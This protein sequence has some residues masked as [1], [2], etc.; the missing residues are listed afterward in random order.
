MRMAG[1]V[2]MGLFMFVLAVVIGVTSTGAGCGGGAGTINV[3]AIPAD[4]SSG[5]YDAEQ[6]ENAGHIRNTAA[7]MG[8]PVRAQQIGV[9]TAMGDSSLRNI[10]YGDWETSGVTNPDGS[11]T[12]SIGLFQQQNSWGSTTSLPGFRALGCRSNSPS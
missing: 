10:G 11:R 12:T 9:M 3:S 6:M 5:A 4:A 2:L 7:A 1:G 8:L